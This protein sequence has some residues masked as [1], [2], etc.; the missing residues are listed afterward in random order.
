MLITISWSLRFKMLK[1][2]SNREK[3]Q[4]LIF[5]KLE[6]ANVLFFKLVV[7]HNSRSDKGTFV[8]SSVLPQDPLL[9]HVAGYCTFERGLLQ[10][11]HGVELVSI[12]RG[13]LSHQEHL[14]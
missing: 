13:H 11:L 6:E 10:D 8:T 5:E 3:K 14:Q 1:P 9:R 2:G 4:M 7:K 12:G